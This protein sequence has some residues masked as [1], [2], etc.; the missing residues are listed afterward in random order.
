MWDS[1]L[2]ILM[3]ERLSED[4]FRVLVHSNAPSTAK[5]VLDLFL[6]SLWSIIILPILLNHRLVWVPGLCTSILLYPLQQSWGARQSSVL[7]RCK[8]WSQ[9]Q[10]TARKSG[11]QK[12]TQRISMPW[13]FLPLVH[14]ALQAPS[15]SALAQDVKSVHGTKGFSKAL[16][17]L[18]LGSIS[19]LYLVLFLPDMQNELCFQGP[20]KVSSSKMVFWGDSSCF[21]KHPV[22]SEKLW[23]LNMK[24]TRPFP[25]TLNV[26]QFWIFWNSAQPWLTHEKKQLQINQAWTC[27]PFKLRSAKH[28]RRAGEVK[29]SC[30]ASCR[31]SSW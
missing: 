23:N 30:A 15:F 21:S 27:Q 25:C 17:D 29:R 1:S 22:V 8:T 31:A 19:R 24:N 11:N 5:G 18:C 10:D 28:V 16:T 3:S 9:V 12:N 4:V 6:N 20:K 14:L 13:R 26:G 7:L 2:R